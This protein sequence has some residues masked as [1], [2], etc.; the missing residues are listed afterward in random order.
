MTEHP[1]G[2]TGDFTTTLLVGF[3]TLGAFVATTLVARRA[4]EGGATLWGGTEGTTGLASVGLFS[5]TG[6]V[7]FFCGGRYAIGFEAFGAYGSFGT[8]GL[9]L[10]AA[11]MAAFARSV[12]I[13]R[14]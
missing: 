13:A 11:A 14:L 12:C 8:G 7:A 2:L 6:T 5:L 4:A 3:T 1:A 9:A 10:A